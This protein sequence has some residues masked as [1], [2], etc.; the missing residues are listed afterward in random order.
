MTKH[1][2][3][4]IKQ[5]FVICLRGIWF[6][7][8]KVEKDSSEFQIYNGLIL[9]GCEKWAH[10]NILHNLFAKWCYLHKSKEFLNFIFHRHMI[11]GWLIFWQHYSLL[12]NKPVARERLISKHVGTI[13]NCYGFRGSILNSILQTK[14]RNIFK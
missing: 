13:C 4:K 8:F 5:L 14:K 12:F 11:M 2:F 3:L 10:R 9:E 6:H 7:Y 1:N